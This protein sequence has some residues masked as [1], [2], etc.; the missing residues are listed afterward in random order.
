MARF[1]EREAEITR[2]AQDLISGLTS[3]IDE[4]PTPPV[5][6]EQL[7]TALSEYV[8]AHE[9]A[10]VGSAAAAQGTAVT[11]WDAVSSAPRSPWRNWESCQAIEAWR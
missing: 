9:A 7:R 11:S 10:V 8:A 5:L 2:L 6:P 3:Y 1:P 4:Y